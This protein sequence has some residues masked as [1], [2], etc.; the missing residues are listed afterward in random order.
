VDATKRNIEIK[1]RCNDLEGV[2]NKALALGAKD[3]GVLEQVDTFYRA[4]TAR[5]KLRETAGPVAEPGG[6]ATGHGRKAEL[7]SYRRPD[8]KGARGCDYVVCPVSD[9][10]P[11]KTAL[12]Y[13]ME[14]AGVVSKKRHLL[15]LRSTRIH[16]DMV[17]GMGNFVELETVLSGQTDEAGKKEMEGIAAGLGLKPEEAVPVPYVELLGN[18]GSVHGQ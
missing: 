2:R 18:S 10:D 14:E 16:L 13:A 8:V 15:L 11:L 7:I 6:R 9:P 5:L 17:E 3:M 12:G 4:P 1:C